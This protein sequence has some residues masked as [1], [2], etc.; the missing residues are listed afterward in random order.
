MFV[1]WHSAIFNV[2]R[3]SRLYKL[4]FEQ[5]EILLNNINHSIDD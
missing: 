1:M 2:K 5:K 4:H 3:E